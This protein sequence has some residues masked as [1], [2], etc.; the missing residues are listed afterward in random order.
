MKE[1]EEIKTYLTRDEKIILEQYLAMSDN[2]LLDVIRHHAQKLGKIPAK[3]D[4]ELAW[5][6]KSRF[7]PWSRMLEKAG[8]KPAS[9]TYQRRK[10]A[11]RRK[12][13]ISRGKYAETREKILAERE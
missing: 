2:E 8:V 3:H 6:F 1:I 12:K 7:G 11:S 9:K 5:Y 4:V 10:A 13:K